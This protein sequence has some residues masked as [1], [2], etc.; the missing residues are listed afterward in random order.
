MN[1]RH[2]S[3]DG[4]RGFAALS[5][6]FAH[7]GFNI[8]ALTSI[9]VIL[10]AYS[11][12][13]VGT[14]AVQILFVLSGFLM[15]YLYSEE[16]HAFRFIRK[17]YTRIFPV[18]IV[19]ITYIWLT[20]VGIG[21]AWYLQ[22]VMLFCLALIF[23]ITWK[24][25]RKLDS[26]G[27]M[28]TFIFWSFLF[29][30][31]A[32]IGLLVLF[33]SHLTRLGPFTYPPILIWLSNLLLNTDSIHDMPR[34]LN[35]AWTLVPEVLFYISFPFLAIPLILLAKKRGWFV[36]LLLIIGMTKIFFD[37]DT[38][39]YSYAGLQSMN[40]AR[41]SGFISG[42][43]IG[44]IYK[45]NGKLW[46]FIAKIFRHSIVGVLVFLLFL[47]V[48]WSVGH[49][50]ALGSTSFETLNY[51]YL[52]SSWVIALLVISVLLPNTVMN[53]IFRFK[54]IAFFG[55]ISYS[56]YL[57]HTSMLNIASSVTSL[58]T[59]I[60]TSNVFFS[61]INL[62]VGL[63]LTIM[64]SYLLFRFIESLYFLDKKHLNNKALTKSIEKKQSFVIP[65]LRFV[66]GGLVFA[67]LIL[68]FYSG[69]YAISLL[70]ARNPISNALA[71][72]VSEVPLSQKPLIIPFTAQNKNLSEV[73]MLLRY[74][75]T[76]NY[77]ISQLKNH[78]SLVFR[79]LTPDK[80]RVIVES[81]RDAYEVDGQLRFPFGFPMQ[82]DSQGKTYYAELLL[83][84]PQNGE[85]ILVN[86][87]ST[88]FVS[89]YI[90]PPSNR[91]TLLPL[92]LIN[93][94]LFAL[95]NSDAQFALLFLVFVLALEVTPK[96]ITLT[97]FPFKLAKAVVEE[98]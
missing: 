53:K 50:I 84:G 47:Y 11:T 1:K 16:A 61:V 46:N 42:V 59:P 98:K 64:V 52:L 78:R 94:I 66:W 43:T 17:R 26:S 79:L 70:V 54:V 72:K 91:I 22:L 69:N 71:S 51:Y 85:N 82:S 18:Y 5:V 83:K 21:T 13:A 55:V 3:L 36:G 37:L 29:I 62:L 35:Q 65:R 96:Y 87:S 89:V 27:K 28:R 74:T 41:A 73:V 40:I 60:I 33:G 2:T 90:R 30:Q 25:I 68:L 10:V 75:D 39:F 45:S 32:V 23:H 34:I 6:F 14:N 12:L 97:L 31:I 4:L 58:L 8:S 93:R 80:K 20:Y 67:L 81:K 19:I 38:A 7:A 95:T 49:E 44:I 24:S 48:Q 15:A 57:I 92:F 86:T 63:A 77:S 88:S 76:S 9:P 56:V